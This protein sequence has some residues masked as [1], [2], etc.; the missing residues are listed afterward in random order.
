M[1]EMRATLKQLATDEYVREYIKT[2]NSL[3]TITDSD[4]LRIEDAKLK[5]L[6]R[7]HPEV[8]NYVNLMR[9]LINLSYKPSIILI[10]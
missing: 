3:K 1:L 7:M 2:Y 8:G 6:E 4:K 9:Y 10:N 5:F